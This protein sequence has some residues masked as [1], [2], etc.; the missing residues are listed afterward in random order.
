MRWLLA[1]LIILAV[2]LGVPVSST[3]AYEYDGPSIE[4]VDA[5]EMEA[6]EASPAQPSDLGEGS[7]SCSADARGTST[8]PVREVLPQSPI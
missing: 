7:V 6:A 3:A 4:R 8:T 5:R 2:G 1:A